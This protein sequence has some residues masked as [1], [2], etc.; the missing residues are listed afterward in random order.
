MSLTVCLAPAKTIAYP[1][2]GGHLWVYLH[3]ALGLRALGCR[4]IWLEGIDPGDPEHD[5]REMVTTLKSRLEPY[6]L[7]ESVALFSLT[8][9]PLPPDVAE[10]ALAERV[11]HP[12]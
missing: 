7:A 1:Q 2:G 8:D 3:W 9:E 12:V 5:P 4:V 6:G 10:Q 11:G